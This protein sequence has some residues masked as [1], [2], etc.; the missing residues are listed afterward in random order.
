[1]IEGDLRF[2][3][4]LVTALTGV[5]ILGVGTIVVLLALRLARDPDIPFPPELHLPEGAR[6]LAV[7]AAA[8]WFAVVTDDERILVFD[9]ATG[10]LRRDIPIR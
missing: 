7:T 5:M 10:T 2:L 9:R 8:D 3:R 1:M 6:P 4:R